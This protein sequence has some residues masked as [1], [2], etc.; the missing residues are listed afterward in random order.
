MQRILWNFNRYYNQIKYKAIFRFL[1]LNI[2]IG[3]N[4]FNATIE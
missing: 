1:F 2:I 3:H 4:I